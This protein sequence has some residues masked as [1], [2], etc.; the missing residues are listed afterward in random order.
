VGA[1]N[2]A[3]GNAAGVVRTDSGVPFKRD[4]GK[5]WCK[6]EG[7]AIKTY[8][9]WER[10]FVTEASRQG[11]LPGPRQAGILMRI[12]PQ[13]MPSDNMPSKGKED[14]EAGITIGHGESMITLPAGY[15]VESIADLVKALNRHV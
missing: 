14:A 13:T 11:M 9:Y 5:N 1:G 4:D 3:C 15:T 8:Y 7:I 12:D 2:E 6:A 10:Q